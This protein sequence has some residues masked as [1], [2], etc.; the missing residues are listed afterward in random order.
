MNTNDNMMSNDTGLNASIQNKGFVILNSTF[1]KYNWNLVK[2]D[3]NW[4]CYTKLG[5]ETSYFDFKILKDKIIVSVPIK[6]SSY[7]FVT[8]FNSYFEA[9][10]YAEEKL[11]DY[12]S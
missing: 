7:Q 9:C 10:E 6:N 4:V 2:N 11:I 3:I 1:K 12:S 8:N 5:D